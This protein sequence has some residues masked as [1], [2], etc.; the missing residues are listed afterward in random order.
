ML[1]K[2]PSTLDRSESKSNGAA[3]PWST[4]RDLLLKEETNENVGINQ[5]AGNKTHANGIMWTVGFLLSS[6]LFLYFFQL[7]NNIPHNFPADF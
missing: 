2:R 4:L 3:R 6:T 1:S 7:L 5:T